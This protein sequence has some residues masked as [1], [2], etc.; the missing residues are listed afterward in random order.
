M[1]ITREEYRAAKETIEAYEAQEGTEESIIK[2]VLNKGVR[3]LVA[4]DWIN[5]DRV[6]VTKI[7][8]VLETYVVVIE[9]TYAYPVD[10]E[11]FETKLG[12]S[13]TLREKTDVKI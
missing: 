13:I 9:Y 8:Y 2:R 4:F 10:H 7:R 11:S 1:P 12:K 3:E 5:E 6:R